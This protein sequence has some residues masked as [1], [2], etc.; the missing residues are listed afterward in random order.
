MKMYELTPMEKLEEEITELSFVIR[1]KDVEIGSLKL[2]L[3]KIDFLINRTSTKD[4][5]IKEE[6]IKILNEEDD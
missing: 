6:I 4:C 2:I 1:E 3:H 5:K